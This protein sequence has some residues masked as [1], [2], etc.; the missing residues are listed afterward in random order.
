VEDERRVAGPA[1]LPPCSAAHLNKPGLKPAAMGSVLAQCRG[2]APCGMHKL[3]PQDP[4]RAGRG[5]V[6]STSLVDI[7]LYSGSVSSA[8]AGNLP[9]LELMDQAST[10][11]AVWRVYSGVEASPGHRHWGV[12][13]D[14][15][16][17]DAS[18]REGGTCDMSQPCEHSIEKGVMPGRETAAAVQDPGTLARPKIAVG[19]P[20]PRSWRWSSAPVR[21]Q[22]A[23]M[24][25][26]TPA[27]FGATWPS[28]ADHSVGRP[29][30]LP[31]TC[32]A[33]HNHGLPSHRGSA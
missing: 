13:S 32:R 17:W 22:V 9:V 7:S 3:P 33:Q 19:I 24:T 25:A 30:Q 15:V 23:S 21:C 18:A 11:F 12:G 10:G 28:Q 8:Y 16:D 1:C 29:P 6:L 14:V 27:L 31:A 2:P 4:C 20:D 5:I 26:S